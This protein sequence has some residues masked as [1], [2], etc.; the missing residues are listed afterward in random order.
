MI[1]ITILAVGKM[2]E[3]FFTDAMDEYSKRLSAYCKLDVVEVRDEKTPDNPT[4]TEKNAILDREGQQILQKIP[5]G[6]KV[7]SLCVEGKQ[8]SSHRFADVISGMAVNGCSKIVFVIGGSM[9]LSEKV[10][11]ISDL[12]LSFSEMTFPHMLMR[13]ILAEQLY[14]GFTIMN[15]KTYHK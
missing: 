12:R 6:A 1:G 13:V 4:E 15:G 11:E 5:K 10:K 8:M 2:K 9:G 14:R 3:K 7:V